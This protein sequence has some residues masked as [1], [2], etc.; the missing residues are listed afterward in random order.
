MRKNQLGYIKFGNAIRYPSIRVKIV[1]G[2]TVL[3]L[4]GERSF[5]KSVFQITAQDRWQ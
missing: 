5:P 1:V 2:Y 4:R 3:S